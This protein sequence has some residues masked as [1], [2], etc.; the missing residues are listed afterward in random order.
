VSARAGRAGRAGCLAWPLG[1][2]MLIG[3]AIWGWNAARLLRGRP[4][5]AVVLSSAVGTVRSRNGA[6]Y[7]PRVTYRYVVDGVAR[8]GDAVFPGSGESRGR[9]WAEGIAERFVPGDSTV[10]FVERA[11]PERAYLVRQPSAGVL[12][13][14]A[15]P[16]ALIGVLALDAP[17]PEADPLPP[18]DPVPA[19]PGRWALAPRDDPRTLAGD[20]TRPARRWTWIALALATL[21]L[22]LVLAAAAGEPGI[23][24]ALAT[25][26]RA[27]VGDGFFVFSAAALAGGGW[28]LHRRRRAAADT[29]DRIQ[30]ARLLLDRAVLRAGDAVAA[31]AD[32]ALAGPH[33]SVREIVLRLERTTRDVRSGKSRGRDELAPDARGAFAL[34]A[35]APPSSIAKQDP[36]RTTWAFTARLRF[37][38]GHE[39][40]LRFPVRVHGGDGA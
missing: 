18:P 21:H 36:E 20:L 11:A 23:G 30:G 8:E 38:D 31:T 17:G 33:Q 2:F 13:F 24:R 5:P 7:A 6:S 4:T 27:T 29:A 14:I 10:A 28:Y 1:V 16:L 15:V 22:A 9:E 37:I 39:A 32:L 26:W 19:S 12:V 25:L 34:P 40:G 35:S 3:L